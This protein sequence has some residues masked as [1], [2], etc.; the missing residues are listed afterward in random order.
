MQSGQTP[1][2]ECWLTRPSASAARSGCPP[3]HPCSCPQTASSCRRWT[4]GGRRRGRHALPR[5][6]LAPPAQPAQPAWP[7]RQQTPRPRPGTPASRGRPPAAASACARDKEACERA[8]QRASKRAQRA[9]PHRRG[10]RGARS[11]RRAHARA[12]RAHAARCSADAPLAPL[13]DQ[14]LLLLCLHLAGRQCERHVAP[15]H[16]VR[17]AQFVGAE[18]QPVLG[19]GRVG[20]VHVLCE[21]AHQV[22]A[23]QRLR[24]VRRSTCTA[25]SAGRQRRLHAPEAAP[26]DQARGC[27]LRRP[28]ASRASPCRTLVWEARLQQGSA[29]GGHAAQRTRP[30]A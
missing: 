16:A 18:D 23:R 5:F 9:K 11:A 28:Q 13:H 29:H 30:P 6:A 2:T 8:V 20:V 26:R 17:L 12:G 22:G 4:R 3:P 14:L 15:C 1:S 19:V 10:T 25:Y 21:S 7:A 27:A 24:N